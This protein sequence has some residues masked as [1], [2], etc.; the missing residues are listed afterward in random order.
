MQTDK[1]IIENDTWN[2]KFIMFYA[3]NTNKT[4]Q[5]ILQKVEQNS[6]GKLVRDT[7]TNF[8]ASYLLRIQSKF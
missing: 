6:V 8:C 2:L 3:D 5:C 7:R 1:F 4:Y